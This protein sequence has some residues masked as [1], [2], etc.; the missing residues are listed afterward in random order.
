MSIQVNEGKIPR[1]RDALRI[2]A[3]EMINWPNLEVILTAT[4]VSILVILSHYFL[5]VYVNVKLEY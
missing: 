2:L 3:E 1:D 5:L 4:H